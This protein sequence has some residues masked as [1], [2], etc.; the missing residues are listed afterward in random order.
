MIEFKNF[1]KSYGKNSVIENTSITIG[2]NKISFLMGPNGCGKTT[3]LKCIAGL[4]SYK[5][6]ISYNEDKIDTIRKDSLVIWDDCPFYDNLSGVDNL[7]VL[8]ENINIRKKEI[9]EISNKYFTKET[10]NRK[11]KTYS[12]G[13]RKKLALILHKLLNPTILIMDEISNGLDYDTMKLLQSDIKKISKEKNIILTGHQFSFYEGLVE[14][15]LIFKEKTIKN[16]T[17]EYNDC[18]SLGTIYERYYFD[19]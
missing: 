7:S 15:V 9:Y 14:E 16:V 12:Y 19:E 17:E 6:I 8:S 10:L 4:E 13:Q 2:N 1:S 18:K 11:V 5:G 3:L